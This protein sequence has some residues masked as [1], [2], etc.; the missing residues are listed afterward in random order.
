MGSY[1]GLAWIYAGAPWS[2]LQLA[3]KDGED[4]ARMPVAQ[5][6][7]EMRMPALLA[8]H[9]RSKSVISAADAIVGILR[10]AISVTL[11]RVCLHDSDASICYSICLSTIPI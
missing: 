2:L 11:F 6:R 10:D 5:C 4:F 3:V 9:A 1:E 7:R 8:T